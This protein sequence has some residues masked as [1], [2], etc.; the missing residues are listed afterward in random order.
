MP[1]MYPL[2]LLYTLNGMQ[3]NHITYAPCHVANVATHNVL[4]N[5][6]HATKI[7]ESILL[8]VPLSHIAHALSMDLSSIC[9][10]LNLC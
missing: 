4:Y 10:R 2:S 6:M 9:N 5:V 7:L 1:Q 3:G 8:I